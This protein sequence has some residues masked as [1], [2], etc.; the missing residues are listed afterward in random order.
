MSSG[1]AA[2][3]SRSAG[4]RLAYFQSQWEFTEPGPNYGLRPLRG[5]LFPQVHRLTADGYSGAAA[6][7]DLLAP[8][9]VILP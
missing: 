1:S 3:W 7:F 5:R 9:P 4:R 6:R 8:R 2:S